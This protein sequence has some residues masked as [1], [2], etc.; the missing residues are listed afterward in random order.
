VLGLNPAE[1]R[2]LFLGEEERADSTQAWFRFAFGP[3]L[4]LL[5]LVGELFGPGLVHQLPE[6]LVW[7]V[8]GGF[9]LKRC[10]ELGREAVVVLGHPE[11]YP[12]FGFVPSA[13]YGIRWEHEV[14]EEVFMVLEVQKGILRR[15]SG[16][17]KYHPAFQ[18]V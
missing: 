17:I 8:A 16:T 6:T 2:Q 12:R 15:A 9:G 3:P 10:E 14:P 1:E 18:G 5:V 13:R 7:A 11:F 4:L